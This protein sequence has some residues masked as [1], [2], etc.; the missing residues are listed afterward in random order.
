VKKLCSY[1]RKSAFVSDYLSCNC[2][3]TV[4]VSERYSIYFIKFDSKVI[5]DMS[6]TMRHLV[7]LLVA[8][9]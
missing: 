4:K 8:R 5:T 2:N 9:R 3:S 6:D 1:A 7:A